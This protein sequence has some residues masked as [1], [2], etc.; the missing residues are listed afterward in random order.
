VGEGDGRGHGEGATLSLPAVRPSGHLPLRLRLRAAAALV[1]LLATGA[2]ARDGQDPPRSPTG[3]EAVLVVPAQRRA[4]DRALG[5]LAQHQQPGGM[6]GAESGSRVADTAL[7]TLAL[8]AGGST[9]GSGAP[10]EGGGIGPETLRG[11]YAKHVRDALRYLARLAWADSPNRP[12]GYIQD[13]R[14]SRMHGHGFATLALAEACGNLGAVDVDRLRAY[15]KAGNDPSALRVADQVR[16]GLERAVELTERAQDPDTGGWFYEPTPD[17]HEGSMTVTQIVALRAAQDAG[18]RVNGH[19]TRLAYEYVRKSQNK[20]NPT[21][22]GGFAYQTTRMDRVSYGL[23]AAALSTLFG[24]GR[25]GDD[26]GD[27]EAIRLGL[28]YM[29]RNLAEYLE[30]R[31]QWYYY[32]LFYGA[33]ALYLSA[34]ERRIREQWPKI[35]AALLSQQRQDGS[36]QKVGPETEGGEEYS[37]AIAALTLLVPMETLPIFQRR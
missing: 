20:A 29:D 35:R 18:V 19:V 9:V 15:V 11:P 37:T 24:L 32:N 31:T 2:L 26:K 6:W 28:D 7:A 27:R 17:G 30:P 36:F 25:Y 5:W 14:V 22:Y 8:M 4:I 13:D 34:D 16:W 21:H 1:G 33:Q 10:L 3:L 23:T 12:A